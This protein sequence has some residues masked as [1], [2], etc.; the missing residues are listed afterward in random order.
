ME[1]TY[2]GDADCVVDEPGI[3]QRERVDD[4]QRRPADEELQHDD[5]QH[6]DHPLLVLQTLFG[7]RPAKGE[8]TREISVIQ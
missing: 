5:E 1:E 3:E 6:L 7:V 4:V 8:N 2:C